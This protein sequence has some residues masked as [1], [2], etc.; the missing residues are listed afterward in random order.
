MSIEGQAR[1][2]F[3]AMRVFILGYEATL[4]VSSCTL[5]LSDGREPN[6]AKITLVNPFDRYITTDLDIQAVNPMVN[7]AITDLPD[8]NATIQNDLLAVQAVDTFNAFDPT[9]RMALT[10]GY[11]SQIAAQKQDYLTRTQSTADSIYRLIQQNVQQIQDPVK[12]QILAVKTRP[13]ESVPVSQPNFSRTGTQPITSL[14]EVNALRGYASRYPLQVGDCIFHSND[15]VRIFWRDPF[16]PAVWFHMF[17]GFITDITDEVDA[18]NRK[19]ITLGCEDATRILRYA[20][21]TTNPGLFDISYIQQIEDAV[22]RTFY[23]ETGFADM[24]LPEI[25]YTLIFGSDVAGTTDFLNTAGSASLP[26]SRPFINRRIN[27]KGDA[28][29]QGTKNEGVGCFDFDRSITFVFGPPSDVPDP[30]TQGTGNNPLR[31]TPPEIA[32]KEISLTGANA[33]AVYQAVIDHQVRVSDLNTMVL[34]GETPLSTANMVKDPRTG[35]PLISEVIKALGE[36]PQLYPVDTGRLIL[37]LPASLGPDTNRNVLWRDLIQGVA[38]QTTFRNRLATI[39]DILEHIE[40]SFYASPKGDLIC[41]MPLYDFDPDDFGAG[42]EGVT[43][44]DLTQAFKFHNGAPV[45][46]LAASV[47]FVAGEMRGPFG[48]HYKV[49][50]RDVLRS[51]RSFVDSKIRTQFATD[52]WA[53]QAFKATGTAQAWGAAPGVETLRALIP[54]FGVR[55]ESAEPYRQLASMESAKVFSA[56]KLN[57]L[58]A[59]ARS[60]S[61]DALPNLRLW[62][63][64]PTLH[65]ERQYIATLRS[66]EH[67]LLWGAQGAMTMNIGV[68]YLRGWDGLYRP[69][70]N[71]PLYTPLGGQASRTMNYAV[72]FR[73][74]AASAPSSANPAQQGQEGVTPATQSPTVTPNVGTFNPGAA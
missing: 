69:G 56:L 59:D 27:W 37:L 47:G 3:P 54:Q 16:N 38:T 6:T 2:A 36:N 26:P 62:P 35:Q 17:A 71:K 22:V 40:F 53:I 50:R 18:D 49:A 4:D 10:Q 45:G 51:A 52:N 44:T 1:H 70:T 57:Q 43:Q 25:L 7:L 19:I 72:L 33:L 41:E 74:V 73:T 8:V 48:P 11:A 32:R 63:N 46:S 28:S 29:G 66:V 23:N 12:R 39:Y 31:T 13:E 42:P 61:V 65:T 34:K 30:A 24:T 20:R 68:N 15:P 5:T 64:R 60:S 67:T 14:A 21:I 58:N 55:F 9:T